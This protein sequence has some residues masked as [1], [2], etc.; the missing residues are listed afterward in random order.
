MRVKNGLKFFDSQHLIATV[1]TG[2]G[3]RIKGK[4]FI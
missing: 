2:A 4:M 1:L 3:Q